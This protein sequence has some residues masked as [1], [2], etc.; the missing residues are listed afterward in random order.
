MN[1]LNL[2][3]LNTLHLQALSFGL[4]KFIQLLS[5]SPVLETLVIINCGVN[6]EDYIDISHSHLEHFVIDKV[7]TCKRDSSKSKVCNIRASAP[8][9]RTVS[10]KADTRSEYSVDELSS[11]VIMADRDIKM[12]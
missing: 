4:K 1:S 11:I 2:P 6:G 8:N 3:N 9:L 12:P 7:F 5:S 10:C